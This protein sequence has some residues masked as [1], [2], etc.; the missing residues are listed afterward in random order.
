MADVAPKISTRSANSAPKVARQTSCP[1]KLVFPE[2]ARNEARP[3]RTLDRLHL[4]VMEMLGLRR[5]LT[6]DTT[7]GR[8]A[9]ALG[10]EVLTPK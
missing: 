6:N 4:A 2:F 7:Q 10:Y 5:I 1:L 8:A 3:C 9:V